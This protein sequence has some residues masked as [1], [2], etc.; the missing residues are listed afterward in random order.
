MRQECHSLNSFAKTHLISKNAIQPLQFQ[1]F[2]VNQRV[3]LILNGQNVC[4][5]NIN[6][7]PVH[8]N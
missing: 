4:F 8:N 5:F 6:N 7:L 1:N 3:V 2:K